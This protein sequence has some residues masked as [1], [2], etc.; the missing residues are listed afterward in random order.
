MLLIIHFITVGIFVLLG[1]VFASGR[2]AFLIA[3]YNTSS[4]KEKEKY[5]EK[6]L[7]KDMSKLM[8]SLAACWLVIAS[9]EIF[10]TMTLLWI[11]LGLF[12]VIIIVGVVYMNTGNRYKK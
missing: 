10:K 8:F 9:S 7:C 1:V 11:G 6:K 2:G 4:V 3:G 5:D 12:V